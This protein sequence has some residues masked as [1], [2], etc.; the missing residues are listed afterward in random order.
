MSQSDEWD[1]EAWGVPLHQAHMGYALT[2]FSVRMLQHMKSLGA[3]YNAEERRSFVAA[4]RYAGWLMGTPE[5]ILFKD[6][7]EAQRLF[8]VAMLCE[9]FGSEDAII[10]TN[11]AIN[12]APMVAGITDPEQRKHLANYIYSVVRAL[13]GDEMSDGMRFPPSSTFGV[14]P[15]FRARERYYRVR[16]RLLPRY[17]KVHAF[18]NF[19]TLLENTTFDDVGIDYRWPDRLY[20]EMSSQW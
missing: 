6:E 17:G 12:S 13:L 11:G 20:S 3:V 8:D 10:L 7:D 1:T 14:L 5:T 2:T 15:L 18:T 9:P 16:S 4:W 19:A